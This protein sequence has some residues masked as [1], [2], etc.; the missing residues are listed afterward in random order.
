M[1]K[2]IYELVEMYGSGKGEV[3]MWDAVRVISEAVEDEMSDEARDRLQREG[4]EMMAGKHYD[5]MFAR[6]AV[7]QMYYVDRAGNQHSAPYWTESSVRSI[8][9]QVRGDIRAYNFWD[10]FVALNMMAADNYPLLE[11][12]FPDEDAAQRDQRIVEMTVSWLRDPDAL[13]PDT[14]IW[15]YLNS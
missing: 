4:Y 12:W 13:H 5:E 2:T 1:D 8:Y 7:E 14:K 15:C 6:E 9:D 3:T 11:R 10:F